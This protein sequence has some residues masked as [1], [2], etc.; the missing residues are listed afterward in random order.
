[1]IRRVLAGALT[2]LALVAP[3]CAL[4]ITPPSSRVFASRLFVH[5]GDDVILSTPRPARPGPTCLV[6]VN[7]AGLEV[8]RSC[9]DVG[10]RRAPFRAWEQGPHRAYVVYQVGGDG[11]D[12][13]SEIAPIEICVVGDDG[14]C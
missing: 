4:A 14:A 13:A 1:M 6:V 3:A 8:Y 10:S 5:P 7:P 9:G 11:H 2:T 12:A